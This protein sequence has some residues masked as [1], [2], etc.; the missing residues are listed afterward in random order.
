MDYALSQTV[1]VSQLPRKYLSLLKSSK[2]KGEPVIL[3]RHNKPVG[4]I[5]AN[6]VLENLLK[7][8]QIW[9]E[10]KVLQLVKSGDKEFAQGKTVTRLPR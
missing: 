6:K 9:E 3:V 8:K 1:P 5:V 10:E 4:A 2:K 7:I